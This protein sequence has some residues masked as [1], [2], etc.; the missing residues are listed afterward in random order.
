MGHTCIGRSRLA[1]PRRSLTF[2]LEGDGHVVAEAHPDVWTERRK[3]VVALVVIVN[4]K[5]ANKSLSAQERSRILRSCTV[6]PSRIVI[7]STALPVLLLLHGSKMSDGFASAMST[8]VGGC[9][10]PRASP[11]EDSPRQ[12]CLFDGIRSEDATSNASKAVDGLN[13]HPQPKMDAVSTGDQSA[14]ITISQR[15]SRMI[16]T[17]EVRNDCRGAHSGQ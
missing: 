6:S 14:T 7:H 15:K 8:A 4:L 1:R 17:E 2:L 13:S 12:G 16:W 11:K 9:D 3:S 10:H 5:V